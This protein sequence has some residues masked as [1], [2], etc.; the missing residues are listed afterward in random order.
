ML[1]KYEIRGTL[2]RGAMGIVYDGW[3]PQIDRRV[4]IKAVRLP[5]EEDAEAIDAL[6]RFKRE[7]QAAGRLSHPNIVGVYD[8]GQTSAMAGG[9]TADIVMEF[10]EGQSLKALLDAE[11]RFPVGETVRIMEELLAGLQFSHARGVIHRDIKPAN[12]MLTTDGRVKIADFGI[13]RIE[14][15]SSMTQA[16]TVLGTPAYMSP[17]QFMGQP[18]DARTDV[19]SSGVL[20]YQMLT[21]ERPFE[22]SMTAIMHK[23]L[24][25]TP[26]R[27]SELSVVAPPGLDPVVARAMQ[28]RPEDRFASAAEFAQ[29]LRRAFEAPAGAGESEPLQGADATIIAAAPRGVTAPASDGIRPGPVPRPANPMLLGGVGAFALLLAAGAAWLEL[30]PAGAPA[31]PAVTRPASHVSPTEPPI[32]SP[33]PAMP[34]RQASL[35]EAPPSV[36][37]PPASTATLPAP[38]PPPIVAA[39]PEP[40]AQAAAPQP[41]SPT[42]SVPS[43]ANPPKVAFALPNPSA[44]R[45]ALAEVARTA[46]C[47]LPRFSVSGEGQ[48]GVSGPVGAGTPQAGLREAV[49]GVAPHAPVTW[50]TRAFDGPYCAALDLVRPIAQPSCPF[51]GLNLKD[52]A[53][54]LKDHQPIVPMLRLPEFPAHLVVDYL[55]HDGSVTHLF[56]TRADHDKAFAAN[57]A[58]TLGEPGKGVGEAGPPFGT[59]M[60]VAVAS[61]VPLF[62]QRRPAEGETVETY[63]PALRAAIEAAQQRN[64]KVAGRAIVLDT[65]EH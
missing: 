24:H 15:G 39:P 14:S 52:E 38:P 12:V 5:D 1:G 58:V 34:E 48:I 6:G 21:G 40:P 11:E 30:R 64:A 53:T 8:Y 17:E 44:M 26:P 46:N 49:E 2:G 43:P 19:Y 4:A 37:V 29:A 55:S 47:A 3:D 60:I 63:L 7:A 32:P 10:V 13:A 20:L 25:I 50:R 33:T 61:S 65:V 22:G 35:S 45:Q 23:V 41:A 28:R 62:A 18:V 42:A 54:T 51:L 27:P 16:G 9:D 57:A 36:A 31:P 56:P 59:D